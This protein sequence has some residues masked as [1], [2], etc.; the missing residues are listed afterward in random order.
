MFETTKEGIPLPCPTTHFSFLPRY[1]PLR[2]PVGVCEL[3]GCLQREILYLCFSFFWGKLFWPVSYTKT[4]CSQR[5]SGGMTGAGSKLGP[6]G[7]FPRDSWLASG[8]LAL[9]P[10]LVVSASRP[11]LSCS[12]FH[13]SGGPDPDPYIAMKDTWAPS[14]ATA[15]AQSSAIM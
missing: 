14:N 13:K 15:W 8:C 9:F 3:P 5:V 4:P 1:I 7:E 2:E 11:L 12:G 10:D 6:A